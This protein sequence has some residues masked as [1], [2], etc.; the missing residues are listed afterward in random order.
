[1]LLSR[2]VR[3]L[4]DGSLAFGTPYVGLAT[5]ARLVRF[6]PLFPVRLSC[7]GMADIRLCGA[8]EVRRLL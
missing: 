3:V 7:V 2:R 4:R 8:V 1:M 6:G 5:L